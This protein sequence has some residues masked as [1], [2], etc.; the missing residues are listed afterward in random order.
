M[1]I[2]TPATKP[3]VT[4]SQNQPG[5]IFSSCPMALTRA[6]SSAFDFWYVLSKTVKSWQFGWVVKKFWKGFGRVWFL[7]APDT[8]GIGRVGRVRIVRIVIYNTKK[9]NWIYWLVPWYFSCIPQLKKT[10]P[11]HTTPPTC[12]ETRYAGD[13]NPSTN[14]SKP[15]PTCWKTRKT[16]N[17]NPFATLLWHSPPYRARVL[18]RSKTFL[19]H[20]RVNV[21]LIPLECVQLKPGNFSSL[22]RLPNLVLEYSF[23][24]F[25]LHHLLKFV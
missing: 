11:T 1:A 19:F 18:D 23:S 15:P 9:Y 7:A 4:A 24:P 13:N 20:E 10:L 3:N 8:K 22:R 21:Y 5:E 16:G 25:W 14:L 2:Q 12:W 17:S 6:P